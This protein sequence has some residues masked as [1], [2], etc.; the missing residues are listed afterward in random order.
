MCIYTT[1]ISIKIQYLVYINKKILLGVSKKPLAKYH[2]KINQY[3]NILDNMV[4]EIHSLDEFESE[5]K[6]PG[7]VVVDFFTTWCGP[8][9]QIAPFIESLAEKFPEVKFIKVDIEKHD[10]IAGPRSISSIPTFHFIVK[11]NMVDEVKGADARSVEEKV[12]QYKVDVNPFKGSGNRLSSDPIDPNVPAL[13]A[14]EARL[15]AFASLEGEHK[16]PSAA[17]TPPVQGDDEDEAALSKALALSMAGENKS[18]TKLAS[19]TQSSVV[20]KQDDADFEA[21][22]AEFDAEGTALQHFQETPGQDWEEEMVPVPVNEELLAQLLDM[23]FP[24]VRARKSLVHGGSLDGAMGWLAEHQDDADIDQPYMVR[25]IDTLPK[26]PLTE[27]EKSAR[28]QAIK[29]KVKDRKAERAR[30]EKAE[31]I[32]R[33]KERRERGQKIDETLE[34]RQRLQR[35]RDADR[36]KREK[37]VS[38][39]YFVY[40]II[41]IT[42]FSCRT[43]RVRDRDCAQRSLRIKSDAKQ[44]R[45]CCRLYLV[46]TA[47]IPPSFSMT[48]LSLWPLLLLILT[49]VPYLLSGPVKRRPLPPLLH[50]RL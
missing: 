28:M 25:K 7:L 20:Q 44:T 2:S 13:S 43:L 40:K 17:S 3:F 24:D 32:R 45:G 22:A 34:E 35:K 21:A 31:E 37:D 4:K 26:P 46:W 5:I 41:C 15:K 8:C 38:D 36:I 33:E 10:D 48:C 47:T 49:P 1:H 18:T 39:A 6:G 19:A 16:R 9:K 12:Q 50:R 11:G 30:Q 23:G 14:R 29:D 42:W 27:E